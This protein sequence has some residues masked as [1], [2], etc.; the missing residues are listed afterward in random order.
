MQRIGTIWLD[1][2]LA[3]QRYFRSCNTNDKVLE[4]TWNTGELTGHYKNS[5]TPHGAEG[6][7][8]L[9]TFQDVDKVVGPTEIQIGE[10]SCF[11][12]LSQC[13]GYKWQW[14]L[15][16][17]CDLVQS[18]V[19]DTGSEPPSSTPRRRNQQMLIMCM[20]EYILAAEVH[21][22]I[23]SLSTVPVGRVDKS[24]SMVALFQVASR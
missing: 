19:V 8:P 23:L 7:L 2:S 18:S 24:Y 4:D 17:Y 9:V 5:M 21:Q 13:G 12:E 20:G 22:Y 6:R 11:P 14:I 10:D 1:V 16:F 3:V 15:V